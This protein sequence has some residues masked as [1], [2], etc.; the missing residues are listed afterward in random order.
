MDRRA[1]RNVS[2]EARQT[3]GQW[4][5]REEAQRH[6]TGFSVEHSVEGQ[7]GVP[8]P[9]PT[10]TV[11][12][13]SSP[14]T[15]VASAAER[16]GAFNEDSDLSN[17]EGFCA[18]ANRADDL[19]L[20][21]VIGVRRLRPTTAHSVNHTLRPRGNAQIQLRIQT[22][23]KTLMISPRR[24]AYTPR[25]PQTPLS[26]ASL[27]TPRSTPIEVSAAPPHSARSRLNS[28]RSTGHSS[29]CGTQSDSSQG[30]LLPQS[31]VRMVCV[32]DGVHLRNDRMLLS[33]TLTPGAREDALRIQSRLSARI[34]DVPL[35]SAFYRAGPAE[36]PKG[37]GLVSFAGRMAGP[38]ER[39]VITASP[40]LSAM[41]IFTAKR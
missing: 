35:F 1:G 11:N 30:V 18:G 28:T 8:P 14:C 34:G 19:D 6:K 15:L 10:P 36:R 21:I 33:A 25:T 3:A 16:L 23:F 32:H 39:E 27:P 40:E 29:L 38:S 4:V 20:P 22:D 24:V 2:L 9:A 13:P 26:V 17:D 7:S 5:S 31:S 41:H 37:S 12:T